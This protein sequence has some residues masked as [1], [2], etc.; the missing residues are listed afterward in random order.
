MKCSPCNADDGALMIFFADQAGEK[1][2]VW[3]Q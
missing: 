3:L 1:G 2:D